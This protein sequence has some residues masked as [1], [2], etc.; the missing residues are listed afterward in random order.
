MSTSTS[1]GKITLSEHMNLALGKAL[2]PMVREG[3]AYRKARVQV[4]G[5]EGKDKDHIKRKM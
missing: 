1:L 2:G 3:I 5:R 4:F